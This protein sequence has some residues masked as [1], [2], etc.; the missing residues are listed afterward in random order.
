M[1]HI[2]KNYRTLFA[3]L[4][5]SNFD[6]RSV[7][8]AANVDWNDKISYQ[9]EA[10]Q[11]LKHLQGNQ[12]KEFIDFMDQQDKSVNEVVNKLNNI[13]SGSLN[14]RTALAWEVVGRNGITYTAEKLSWI[15]APWA[16]AL[17]NEL[18]QQSINSSSSGFA[19]N[20]Q[21]VRWNTWEKAYDIE[22]S[23]VKNKE[24]NQWTINT[25]SAEKILNSLSAQDLTDL[26]NNSRGKNFGP[27][28]KKLWYN[29]KGLFLWNYEWRGLLNLVQKYQEIGWK[30]Y[31]YSERQLIKVVSDFDG[32]GVID[33]KVRPIWEAQ[34]LNTIRNNNWS[35]TNVLKSAGFWW[36]DDLRAKLL[37]SPYATMKALQRWLITVV[38]SWKWTVATLAAGKGAEYNRVL[39]SAERKSVL[40]LSTSEFYK[41]LSN[42]PNESQRR[43][44]AADLA[45]IAIEGVQLTW[46]DPSDFIQ[47]L[48]RDINISHQI[49]SK[50]FGVTYN[51]VWTFGSWLLPYVY[52]ELWGKQKITGNPTSIF[53][54]QV[55]WFPLFVWVWVGASLNWT[56]GWNVEVWY[57]NADKAIADKKIWEAKRI[58][59][60]I[61]WLNN[62]SSFVQS[63]FYKNSQNKTW[64]L[65][66]F[67]QMQQMKLDWSSNGVIINAFT[68]TYSQELYTQLK[69]EWTKLW[70]LALGITATWLPTFSISATNQWVNFNEHMFNWREQISATTEVK[71]LAEIWG[72]YWNHRWK[73]VLFIP[74]K[75]WVAP[76][77]AAFVPGVQVEN[78]NGWVVLSGSIK[79]VRKQIIQWIK[80]ETHTL[81]IGWANQS[82]VECSYS[83]VI[84]SD[85]DCPIDNNVKPKVSIGDQKIIDES[86]RI[87]NSM[88]EEDR[89]KIAAPQRAKR[90]KIRADALW[91]WEKMDTHERINAINDAKEAEKAIK[92]VC[93]IDKQCVEVQT[94]IASTQWVWVYYDNNYGITI[95]WAEDVKEVK[96][97]T[98][99]E[100]TDPTTIPWETDPVPLDPT[101]IPSET[102][103]NP[104]VVP[105]PEQPPHNPHIP[106]G[107]TVTF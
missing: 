71:T 37:A 81:A 11:I 28:F 48:S 14:N 55:S 24:V 62:E 34:L 7:V 99:D 92:K 1:L 90:D 80:G 77:I 103:P 49:G 84:L 67:K 31:A 26:I 97:T 64:D 95:L 54:P 35:F 13:L 57:R 36:V 43:S 68:E 60:S 44:V 17:R 94:A 18:K 61:V 98:T 19:P 107:N 51:G 30:A 46:D 22:E 88:T 65:L 59:T 96:D 79:V 23:W 21:D 16:D 10:W 40:R 42:I 91:R 83:P 39:N 63:N 53:W 102:Q 8:E 106:D 33:T 75:N 32:D 100:P 70:K 66:V 93:W 101:T 25:A 15:N 2:I 47:K 5:E 29:Q 104:W 4:V 72:R 38:N 52:G 9:W 86:L 74:N 85:I 89:E 56:I 78:V 73:R 87:W 6:T 27:V 3:G 105:T 12:R 41:K 58:L 45:N 50:G 82:P 69:N 20:W 76:K